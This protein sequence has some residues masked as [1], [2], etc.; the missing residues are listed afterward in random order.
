MMDDTRGSLSP[1]VESRR[2]RATTVIQA[3]VTTER[4]P[5]E[6]I[7]RTAVAGMTVAGCD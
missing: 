6:R 1:R 4:R 7:Q 5:S 2:E 3:V